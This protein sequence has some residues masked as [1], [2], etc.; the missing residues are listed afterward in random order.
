MKV[1]QE[2]VKQH[3]SKDEYKTS[4]DLREEIDHMSDTTVFSAL[5]KL[6]KKGKVHV[7]K[8]LTE[9]EIGPTPTQTK[10]KQKKWLK[11]YKLK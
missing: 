3:L 10:S 8:I 11:G 2:K 7:K 6:R 1:G 5:R 4:I 9:M